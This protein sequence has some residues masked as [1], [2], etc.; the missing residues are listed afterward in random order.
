MKTY[1]ITLKATAQGWTA[2]HSNPEVA[3]LFGT[4]TIATAFNN[5]CDS[6][7]V[8]TEIS[9]LNPDCDVRFA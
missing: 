2:T 6:F 1:T 5:A 8:L 3:E 7:T 4:A 9:K